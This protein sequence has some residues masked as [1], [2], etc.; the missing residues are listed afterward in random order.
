MSLNERR[1]DS[2]AEAFMRTDLW[3]EYDLT[4]QERTQKP[5]VNPAKIRSTLPNLPKIHNPNLSLTDLRIS[6]SV[7]HR[8]REVGQ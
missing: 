2:K 3:Y 8:I 6:Q 5:I 7:A 4:E 1:E